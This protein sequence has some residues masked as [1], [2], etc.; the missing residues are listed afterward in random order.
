MVVVVAQRDEPKRALLRSAGYTLA[1]AWWVRPLAPIA[2]P[3][4]SS[5]PEAPEGIEAVVAPAPPVYNPGGPVALAL[6]LGD[7]PAAQVAR[8]DAWAAASGAALAVI[9]ARVADVA[10]VEALARAGYTVASEWYVR[11]Q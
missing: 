9:P 2:A 3:T 8:F 4:D 11:P 5:A 1:A 6:S 7:A 10:L